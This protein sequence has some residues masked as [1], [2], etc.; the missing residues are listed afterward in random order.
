MRNRIRSTLF[1]VAVLA[2]SLAQ[3]AFAASSMDMGGE[4]SA[5]P[6]IFDVLVMR[7]IG[8]AMTAVGTVVYLVPV[9]PIMLVTRPTD[10]AKPIGYLI[11]APAS[12]TFKDPIGYH[13]QPQ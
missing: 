4:P 12:F 11:G 1:A 5:V 6:M 3:P 2:L 13:P 9:A 8:L 7:P 10:I